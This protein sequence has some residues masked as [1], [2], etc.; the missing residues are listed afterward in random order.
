M[1]INDDHKKLLKSLGLKE[2]DF[3]R[4]DGTFVT[5]EFDP[6]KG[7]RLYDPDYETSY[8]EYIDVDGWSAWSSEQN[9]FMRDILKGTR[10]EVERREKMDRKLSQEALEESIERKF[11]KKTKPDQE[12]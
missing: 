11:G 7:V 9:T 10:E 4:F 1:D 6:V 8:D 12:S 5:Y 3:E 2:E